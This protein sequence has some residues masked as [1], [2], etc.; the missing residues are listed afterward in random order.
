MLK[1]VKCFS[2]KKNMSLSELFFLHRSLI[3]SIQ[4]SESPY[5]P[6]L[7]RGCRQISPWFR[8]FSTH[9]VCPWDHFSVP[10]HLYG[11]L[12]RLVVNI[13]RMVEWGKGRGGWRKGGEMEDLW[14]IV[15]FTEIP[16]RNMLLFGGLSVHLGDSER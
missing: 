9:T 5:S 13:K 16:R 12:F 1:T 14:R 6:R 10:R 15:L 4:F 7:P 8:R 2:S 11:K 3:F